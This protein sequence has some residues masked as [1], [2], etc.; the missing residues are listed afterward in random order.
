M[1]H[2]KLWLAE[3]RV[4]TSGYDLQIL[5]GGSGVSD[6]GLFIASAG[7]IP[8]VAFAQTQKNLSVNR[9]AEILGFLTLPAG[10]S[11]L[12]RISNDFGWW[13]ILSFVVASMIAGTLTAKYARKVGLDALYA[14]QPFLGTVFVICAVVCWF[15]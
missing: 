4:E 13:T 1:E 6:A 12:W 15:I 2:L 8:L 3:P 5:N 10:I 7:L 14:E 9:Y 11:M